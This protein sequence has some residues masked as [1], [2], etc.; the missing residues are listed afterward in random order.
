MKRTRRRRGPRRIPIKGWLRR[1]GLDQRSTH[2][3]SNENKQWRYPE[4]PDARER[5]KKRTQSTPGGESQNAQT[6]LS[7]P[8]ASH[9]CLLGRQTVYQVSEIHHDLCRGAGHDR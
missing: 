3:K 7:E 1:V 8:F 5:V 9:R 4:T 2:R 6:H